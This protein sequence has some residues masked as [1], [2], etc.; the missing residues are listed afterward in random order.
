MDDN[1]LKELNEQQLEAVIHTDGPSLVIAGAGSG[2]TRVLTYRI[3]QL[4]RQDVPPYKI[5]ALTFTN[6]AAREMQKRIAGIVGP[7]KA[8]A[9]WMGTFHSVFSKILRMEAAAIGYTPDYVIYDTQDSKNVIKAV[10][11]ELGADDRIY[12]PGEVMGRISIAKN[13]L[14][15]HEA[16]L[17]SSNIINADNMAKKPRMGEIYAAYAM[18]CRKNDA[19][20]FDDLLLNTNILLYKNPSCLEK[21]QEKFAYILVDEYQDTNYAQYLILKQLAAKHNNICV[22]GDDAQSIYSFRGA[23]IENILTFKTDY[24]GYQLFKLERNYRSTDII[25]KAANSIIDKN[26]E[27]IPKSLF[28]EKKSSDKIRVRRALSDKEEGLSVGRDIFNMANNLHVPYGD[29]AILYRTNMQSRI[30]EEAMRYYNIP[31]RVYG[32]QSFYQRAEI[33]NILAY[34]RLTVNHNDE[35]SFKRIV[36]YP[37]RGIG[38]TT[39]NKIL[40]IARNYSIS[41]WDIISGIPD[42]ENISGTGNPAADIRMAFEREIGKSTRK[43]LTDF[44]SLIEDF[45]LKAAEDNAYNTADYI[46]KK[47]GINNDPGLDDSPEGMSRKENIQELLNGIKAYCE[48]EYEEGRRGELKK[49]VEGVTLITDQDKEEKS[50]DS[51]TLMTVHASKGLEFPY[52]FITGLEENLF[53]SSQ[54]QYNQSELEEERRLF[55]VA[56]T[57][58]KNIL[59]VYYAATRYKNGEIMQCRPSRFIK[60][61]DNRYVDGIGEQ[62]INRPEGQLRKTGNFRKSIGEKTA[63]YGRSLPVTSSRLVRPKSL[64]RTMPGNSHPVNPEDIRTGME[65]IHPIFGKGKVVTVDGSG[66]NKKARIFFQEHG[67]KIILLKYAKLSIEI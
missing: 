16:Y 13:N 29:F 3:A 22:V 30:L 65:V 46:I 18:K 20:D 4:L 55:Y 21:Y 37:K 17:N 62:R 44:H 42:S 8:S 61:I 32:G 66:N 39:V 36:N 2:K 45:G 14:I 28:S 27:Q 43:K 15:T 50:A 26:K 51:V 53:P 52:V 60:D 58:A 7:G 40:E 10:L 1:F 9:L 57:R 59:S 34:F 63:G 64:C 23:R 6:K 56:V 41:V 12:R 11:K 33:K 54:S 38:E 25:V 5:L 47:A 19:M 35:E 31:Y 67:Q 48:S 24:P 49:F